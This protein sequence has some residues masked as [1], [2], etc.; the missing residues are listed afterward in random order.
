MKCDN[1][2]ESESMKELKLKL[3]S[4]SLK[5]EMFSARVSQKYQLFTREGC[6]EFKS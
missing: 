2:S 1:W 4:L 3:R 5:Y 6:K